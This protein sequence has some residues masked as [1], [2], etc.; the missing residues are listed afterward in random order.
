MLA[1]VMDA[2]EDN[3]IELVKTLVGC[4]VMGMVVAHKFPKPD[5]NP[6]W[7]ATI[8]LQPAQ[9]AGINLDNVAEIMSLSNRMAAGQNG[10]A[11]RKGAGGDC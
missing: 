5:G 10:A 1:A 2:L 6:N 8:S 3:D 7:N 4:R 11:S 9:M